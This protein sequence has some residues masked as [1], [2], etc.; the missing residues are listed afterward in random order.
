LSSLAKYALEL[1]EESADM[2]DDQYIKTE[3]M[4]MG[5]LGLNEGLVKVILNNLNIELVEIIEEKVNKLKEENS[6]N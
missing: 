1:A 2:F 6:H 5:L 4:L 3:H